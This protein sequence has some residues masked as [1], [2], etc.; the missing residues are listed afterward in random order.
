MNNGSRSSI[1]FPEA[2]YSPVSVSF[3][4]SPPAAP[5]F[6]PYTVTTAASSAAVHR[7]PFHTIINFM[8]RTTNGMIFG[9]QQTWKKWKDMDEV[10]YK[11]TKCAGLFALSILITWVPAS[12]NRLYGIVHPHGRYIYPL[13]I[14]SAIVLPLQGFWN[15]FIFFSTSVPIIK[16][17][18]AD[19]KIGR[20]LMLVGKVFRW[21]GN[22]QGNTLPLGERRSA[23]AGMGPN[24]D[25]HTR[26]R[27]ST[28]PDD[29]SPLD[30]L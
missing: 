6:S 17:V 12:T 1:K 16:M 23:V 30:S 26:L 5:K 20:R 9:L 27:A 22:M 8:A 25:S 11:Y 14:A 10:K 2:V 15:A 18:W 29:D 21:E 13:N 7:S 24:N 19:V 4:G 28:R 3:K